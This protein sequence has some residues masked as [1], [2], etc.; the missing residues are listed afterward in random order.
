MVRAARPDVFILSLIRPGGPPGPPVSS[1]P[2]VYA[3][4]VQTASNRLRCDGPTA[5]GSD[6][7]REHLLVGSGRLGV[8]GDQFQAAGAERV[9]LIDVVVN[10]RMTERIGQ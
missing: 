4:P 7:D 1:L 9:G 8:G 6:G 2:E 3:M 5:V 10:E